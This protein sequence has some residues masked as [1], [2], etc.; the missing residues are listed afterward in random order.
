M[1]RGCTAQVAWD[2]NSKSKQAG[3]EGMALGKA[4]PCRREDVD[5]CWEAIN[6]SY[7]GL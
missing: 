3:K 1:Q 4:K 7:L 6:T 5:F 2:G